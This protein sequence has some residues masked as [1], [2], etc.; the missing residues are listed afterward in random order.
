MSANLDDLL[1]PDVKNTL[2]DNIESYE[3]ETNPINGDINCQNGENNPNDSGDSDDY[4][5]S[6]LT[7]EEQVIF[8]FILFLIDSNEKNNYLLNKKRLQY[9]EVK[10]NN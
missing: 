2:K 10:F 3:P 7:Q 6:G 1:D 5:L 8:L 9:F 4:A